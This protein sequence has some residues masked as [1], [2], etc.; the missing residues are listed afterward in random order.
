MKNQK[1]ILTVL[2]SLFCV[3]PS[4]SQMLIKGTNLV[5]R[6]DGIVRK[7]ENPY[8]KSDSGYVRHYVFVK[9]IHNCK[10]DLLTTTIPEYLDSLSVPATILDCP[11]RDVQVRLEHKPD[12]IMYIYLER[13]GYTDV[14]GTVIKSDE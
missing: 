3:L 8:M 5:N 6:T 1:T 9:G 11:S 14:Y 4:F 2:F 13:A 10:F 7:V 12:G